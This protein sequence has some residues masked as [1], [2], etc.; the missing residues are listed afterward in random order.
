MVK[1]VSWYD[2]EWGYSNRCVELAAKVLEPAAVGPSV[3]DR[4]E[5]GERPRRRGRGQARAGARRLQR[6]A[7]RTARSPTTRGSAAALP[8]IEL[9]RERGAAVVLVSHLGRPEGPRP[10][11][12]MAPVADAPGRAARGRG[13]AGAGRRRRRGRG[14]GRRARA[15]RGAAAGE[16]PLRAGR[17]EQ[18]PG[19]RARRSPRLADLY[20]ND[21]FGA[22]HRAHA[23]T[24][25]VAQ[26]LPAYAGLLL[27]RE[28][29]GAGRGPRR[30]RAARW[31]WSSAAPRSPTRSA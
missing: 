14:A 23:T 26:H 10:E 4:F 1:V 2:N 12:S 31:S 8:T 24:E 9:L 25:G 15:R 16:Q 11:L 5:Q 7:R 13:H 22:A 30:P 29:R 19:A 17:D 18:R 21:A 3:V 27:E 28:V 20:V 6:P